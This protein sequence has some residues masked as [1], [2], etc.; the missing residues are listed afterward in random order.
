MD[1]LHS[2]CIQARQTISAML[3][4]A[5]TL[6]IAATHNITHSLCA[7]TFTTHPALLTTLPSTILLYTTNKHKACLCKWQKMAQDVG[8]V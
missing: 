2:L 8:M 4:I 6:Y 5:T 7:S 1:T 3:S